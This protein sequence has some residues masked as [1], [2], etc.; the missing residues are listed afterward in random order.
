VTGAGLT[1]RIFAAIIAGVILIGLCLLFLAS[2]YG[3]RRAA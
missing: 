3:R 2:R 1:V